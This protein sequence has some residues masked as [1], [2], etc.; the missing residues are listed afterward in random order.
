MFLQLADD[1]QVLGGS[2]FN[3][4]LEY[5]QFII[6]YIQLNWPENTQ[7]YLRF[8]PAAL[9]SSARAINAFDALKVSQYIKSFSNVYMMEAT[10]MD[11]SMNCD[12]IFGINS[13]SLFESWLFNP[14]IKLYISGFPVWYPCKDLRSKNWDNNIVPFVSQCKP[15]ILRRFFI[16]G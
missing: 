1:T 6:N 3:S 10:W 14:R 2:G 8:H 15:D 12:A 9:G 4:M 5:V 13:S 7:V 11:A 16:D